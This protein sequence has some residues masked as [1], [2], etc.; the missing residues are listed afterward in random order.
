MH[1]TS[2]DSLFIDALKLKNP[3]AVATYPLTE[4][5]KPIELDA[6]TCQWRKGQCWNIT[7]QTACQ[8]QRMPIFSLT[9]H[10]IES[11]SS[12]NGFGQILLNVPESRCYLQYHS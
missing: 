6:T 3:P 5:N 4:P 1:R 11:N 8:I 12:A 2:A 7:M 10:C 9:N